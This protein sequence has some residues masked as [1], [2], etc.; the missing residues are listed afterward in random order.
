M[1]NSRGRTLDDEKCTLLYAVQQCEINK[2][3]LYRANGEITKIMLSLKS[4]LLEDVYLS[5]SRKRKRF[6]R[7]R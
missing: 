2:L 7:T 1:S 3:D 5:G 4:K 6:Y